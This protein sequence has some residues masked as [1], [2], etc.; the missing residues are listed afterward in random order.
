MFR[1]TVKTYRHS[2]RVAEGESPVDLIVR[3][4]LEQEGAMIQVQGMPG[5]AKI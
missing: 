4:L 2:K 1:E 3:E 5:S